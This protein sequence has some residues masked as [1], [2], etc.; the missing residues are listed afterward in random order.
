MTTP[1]ITTQSLG[2][3]GEGV[4]MVRETVLDLIVTVLL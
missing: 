4:L 1:P 2:G 3:E